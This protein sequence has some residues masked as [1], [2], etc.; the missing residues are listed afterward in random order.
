[1]AVTDL[2]P[3]NIKKSKLRLDSSK[4]SFTDINKLKNLPITPYIE[5]GKENDYY[6]EP[7][8][9]EYYIPK[10]SR[11]AY[12][13]KYLYIELYDPVPVNDNQKLIMNFFKERNEPL[14][15]IEVM[16]NF[17]QFIE[18]IYH[19]YNTHMELLEK[20]S[21]EFKEGISGESKY[22][23]RRALYLNEVLRKSEPK[24][25][26]L[27]IFGDYTTYNIN[28]CIRFCNIKNI[29]H[30]VEDKTVEYLLKLHRMKHEDENRAVDERF[31]ILASIYLDQAFPFHTDIFDE[32][33]FAD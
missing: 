29:H 1:M 24:I 18:P 2:A 27:E 17:P 21:M 11:F 19:S 4:M 28:W 33:D 22:G 8:Q 31:N 6:I 9:I 7:V 20:L 30:A 3:A 23:V 5:E 15:L 12:E 13:T 14:D 10:E 26:S 25:A 32:D 16:N